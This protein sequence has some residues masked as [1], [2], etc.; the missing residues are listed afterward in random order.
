MPCQTPGSSHPRPATSTAA[1]LRAGSHG[2]AQPCRAAAGR[3]GT[4]AA[5]S[6]VQRPCSPGAERLCA[7]PAGPGRAPAAA[8]EAQGAP[9]A[10]VQRLP[11]PA[12]GCP[13][14]AACR[15]GSGTRVYW[16]ASWRAQVS[17]DATAEARPSKGWEPEPGCTADRQGNLLLW[18]TYASWCARHLVL[19]ASAGVPGA[20]TL[21]ALQGLWGAQAD[22]QRHG[23]RQP[24]CDLRAGGGW[25]LVCL[26]A[27]LHVSW[28]TTV[29]V[30]NASGGRRAQAHPWSRR[31]RAGAPKMMAALA[32]PAMARPCAQQLALSCCM[33]S[34]SSHA[35]CWRIPTSS[36]LGVSKGSHR[37]AVK[38]PHASKRGLLA[39]S[40]MDAGQ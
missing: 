22:G 17:V 3:A 30:G 8:Q 21:C 2:G 13:S 28:L 36:G 16:R 5:P 31:E 38:V 11:A 12:A 20:V 37:R 7:D 4:P 34:A 32:S 39:R 9:G 14:V 27:N 40:C 25:Q 10:C 15:S 18:N 29:H 23:A 6:R 19:E 24:G 26:T 35:R 1:G 33:I